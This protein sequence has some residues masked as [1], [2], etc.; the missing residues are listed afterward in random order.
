MLDSESPIPFPAATSRRFRRILVANRGE[1][2]VRIIRAC[3]ELGILATAIHSDVDRSALHVELAD[4][5]INVGGDRAAESYLNIP[6]I[7]A[8][9]RRAGV[10]AVHPGFGFL[11]ENAEFAAAVRD[12]GMAFIGPSAEAIR[13]MGS[14][15]RARRF[16]REL[17]IPVVP[18]DDG[19]EQTPE[20][21]EAAAVR[22]GFPVAI[23]AAAGGGGTGIRVVH[24]PD[25]FA[26]ELRSARQE[27]LAAFGD[28]RLFI[29]RYFERARHVEV[30]LVADNDGNVVHCFDRECSIQRRRQK[31]IEEAPAP[32]LG[33]ATRQ[34]MADAALRIA[35]AA[36]YCSL[37]TVE[38]L[39]DDDTGEFYFLEMNTRLQVEHAVTEMI[40]GIDLVNWQISIAEGQPLGRRQEDIAARGHAIECRLYAESPEDNFA[41]DSGRVLHF[42]SPTGPGIRVDTGIA[43]GLEVSPHYDPMV[44][45]LVCWGADRD[46]ALRRM[47]ATLHR[48]EVAGI[49]TNQRFLMRVVDHPSFLAA[50]TTTRFVETHQDELTQPAAPDAVAH[51]A[52]LASLARWTSQSEGRARTRFEKS[53]RLT[54]GR[55]DLAVTIGSDAGRRLYGVIDGRRY[56]LSA[57]RE[58]AG[59][60]RLVAIDDR[61]MCH[62][63]FDA[64][65]VVHVVM[66]GEPSLAVRF[67]SRFHKA[68]A[69]QTTGSYRAAMTGRVLEVLVAE[70]AVV[71]IADRLIVMESMKMEHV[72]AAGSDG[73]VTKLWAA[74]GS[75]VEKG[76]ILV[77]IEPL[78]STVPCTP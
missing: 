62:R 36:R 11:S 26:V 78:D 57:V 72:T 75:V 53:Y 41:P 60:S 29:E 49:A 66:H 30:Q 42:S 34:K 54:V 50:N 6:R 44:A 63:T 69:S 1:V 65:D 43:S 64:K 5:A 76:E 32:R 51:A 15:T 13:L 73:R 68:A 16:V 55:T 37:G 9:A 77:E 21:L 71:R 10:D 3:R 24:Q 31:V 67:A 56:E 12:A 4:E 33:R 22:L 52:L 48:T 47:R 27:A 46:E 45:K 40:T 20:E 18:G 23:K 25:R 35:R 38:F 8:V 2:A 39:V 59:S 28:A 17:G 61:T 19:D 70:G 14:K 58:G 74:A 7:V